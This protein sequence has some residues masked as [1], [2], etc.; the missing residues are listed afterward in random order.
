[1]TKKSNTKHRKAAD[2]N[3]ETEK[4]IASQAKHIPG[5]R[6]ESINSKKGRTASMFFREIPNDLKAQFK[7]AC[8]RRGLTMLKSV[9]MH[10]EATVRKD[11]D[12]VA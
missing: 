10:M 12:N 3:P 1:M 2:K 4:L 9:I 11:I 5:P 7:A 6:R 8:A